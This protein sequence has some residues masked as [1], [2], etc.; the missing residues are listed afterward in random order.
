MAFWSRA[1]AAWDLAAFVAPW[2]AG[3][4]SIYDHIHGLVAEGKNDLF[5]LPDDEVVS[6]PGALRWVAGGLDGAFGHHG[7]VKPGRHAADV[8]KAVKAALDDPSPLKLQRLYSLLGQSALEYVDALLEWLS[9]R[10]VDLARL[11]DLMEWIARHAPD[12]EPVKVAIALLG[13]IPQPQRSHE[14]L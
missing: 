6:P 14:N 13:V 12:R 4:P 9:S 5:A 7:G 11:E 3:R 10:S 1:R 2:D 8:Q